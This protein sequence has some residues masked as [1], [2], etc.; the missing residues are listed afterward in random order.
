MASVADCATEP[1][2]TK[3]ASLA[4][5]VQKTDKWNQVY[6]YSPIQEKFDYY[7]TS[8]IITIIRKVHQLTSS[9]WASSIAVSQYSD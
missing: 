8:R 5:C 9:S 3:A 2:V 4:C 6:I 1:C 7:Q